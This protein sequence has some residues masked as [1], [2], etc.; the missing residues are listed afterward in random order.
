MNNENKN[1]G[2]F[3]LWGKWTPELQIAIIPLL[4][5]FERLLPPWCSIAH[6][7]EDHRDMTAECGV[8]FEYRRIRLSLGPRFFAGTAPEREMWLIHELMHGTIHHLFNVAHDIA[9]NLAQDN[10]IA[11]TMA[12]KSLREANEGVTT[13]MTT[14]VQ[15]LLLTTQP[16]QP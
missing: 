4:E 12:L 8:D 7:E 10:E 1:I 14:L 15:Q 3:E 11:R 5:K 9:R 13:D 2:R 16:K 6:V